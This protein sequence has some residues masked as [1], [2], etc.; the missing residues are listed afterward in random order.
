MNQDQNDITSLAGSNSTGAQAD[1][2]SAA[3]FSKFG[4][5]PSFLNPTIPTAY[6]VP[7]NTEVISNPETITNPEVQP[8]IE[9]PK[10][11]VQE[12]LPVKPIIPVQTIAAEAKPKPAYEFHKVGPTAD[13]TT[14]QADEDEEKFI[15]GVLKTHGQL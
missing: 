6:E 15:K 10:E 2:N 11:K 14:I 9:K 5:G 7:Q 8:E 1:P 13:I 12:E 4:N 3:G